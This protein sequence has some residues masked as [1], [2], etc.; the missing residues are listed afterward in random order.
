MI[1]QDLKNFISKRWQIIFIVVISF[2]LPA[3]WLRE[4]LVISYAESG[5]TF[6]INPLR[7]LNLS[8]YTWWNIVG[9]G[10]DNVRALPSVSYHLMTSDLQSLGFSAVARQY[11]IF[12]AIL[13]FVS[14]INVFSSC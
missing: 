4:K 3:I 9:L 6:L 2:L 5:C 8:K 7:L 10:V 14:S 1:L 11:L 13:L 12:S